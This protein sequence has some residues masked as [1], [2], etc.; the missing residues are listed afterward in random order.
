MATKQTAEDR[1]APF[2]GAVEEAKVIS[3]ATVDRVIAFL[4]SLEVEDDS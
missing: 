1:L 4:Y 2:Y 3:D